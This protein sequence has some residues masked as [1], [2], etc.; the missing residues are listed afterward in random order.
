VRAE[1]LT[2]KDLD[3]API[4]S[5]AALTIESMPFDVHSASVGGN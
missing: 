2:V 3:R 5:G 4:A 1:N